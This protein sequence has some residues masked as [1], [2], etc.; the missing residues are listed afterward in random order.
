MRHVFPALAAVVAI[1]AAAPPAEAIQF[2]TSS[3]TGKSVVLLPL[4]VGGPITGPFAYSF[5]LRFAP[6]ASEIFGPAPVAAGMTEGFSYLFDVDAALA[7]RYEI[8]DIQFLGRF[9]P[10][11]SPF[12][13]Y[14]YL[15]TATGQAGGSLAGVGGSIGFSNV[16]GV[17]YGVQADTELPLGF[18]AFARGGLTTLLAGGWDTRHNGL[19][20]SNSGSLDPKGATLPMFGLGASW[21]LGPVF[22]LAVGYDLLALPTNM[23]LQTNTLAGGQTW[24]TGLSV[25]VTLLGFSI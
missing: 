9:N 22:R 3:T 8:A 10:S 16:H 15:T 5:G 13:G 12:I 1:A 17:Q 24:V 7:Y 11:V 6:G 20:V 23:R 18:A 14:R 19:T 21:S 2:A 4:R 25:G